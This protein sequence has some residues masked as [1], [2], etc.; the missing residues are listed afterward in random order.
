VQARYNPAKSST[1]IFLEGYTWGLS[2]GYGSGSSQELGGNVYSD[3]VTIGGLAVRKQLVG[4]PKV[5]DAVTTYGSFDGILGL[6]FS[7]GSMGNTGILP[8]EYSV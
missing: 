4:V 6:G 7:A 3:T 5:I 8:R 1:A 2:Y